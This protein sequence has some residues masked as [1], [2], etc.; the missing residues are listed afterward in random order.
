MEL[1]SGFAESATED[2]NI[3]R[4]NAVVQV[5]AKKNGRLK[6]NTDR[7][8]KVIRSIRKLKQDGAKEKN[9]IKKKNRIKLLVLVCV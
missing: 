8:Q 1:F 2:I 9:K 3:V 4:K 6:R 5:T 7:H